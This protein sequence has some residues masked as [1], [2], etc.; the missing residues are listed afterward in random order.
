MR[1]ALLLLVAAVLVSGCALVYR[2]PVFQGNLLETKHVQQLKAGM[3]QQQVFALLGSPA[4]ADA[5]HQDRWD[6]VATQ[7][8]R[9]GEMEVKTLTLWFENDVLA[10]WEGEY[11]PEQDE[12]LA[13]E[14]RKFGNLPKDDRERRRRR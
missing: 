7:R 4:V 13:L 14:M 6:Y 12:A 5:F 9:R 8:R 1:K 3:S 10:R 11:F 2:Q